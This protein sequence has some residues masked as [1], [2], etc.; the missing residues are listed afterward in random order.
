MVGN[1]GSKKFCPWSFADREFHLSIIISSLLI[2]SLSYCA[3]GGGTPASVAPDAGVFDSSVIAAP[4]TGTGTT[5]PES[6]AEAAVQHCGNGTLEP[7]QGESCDLAD[8][9]GATCASLYE[10]KTGEL[11]CN[12]DCTFNDIMCYDE[13]PAEGDT[14]TAGSYGS[15]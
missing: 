5:A 15:P 13:S 1:K 10:N 12:P 4:G 7:D 2:L 14:G 9:G 11:S 8:L 6:L 3:R